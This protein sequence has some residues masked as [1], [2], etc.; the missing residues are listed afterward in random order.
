MTRAR[1]QTLYRQ[2]FT[3]AVS[4]V[5]TGGPFAS[6][7]FFAALAINRRYY[8]IR[9]SLSQFRQHSR[10]SCASKPPE[11]RHDVNSNIWMVPLEIADYLACKRLQVRRIGVNSDTESSWLSRC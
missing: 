8:E 10:S 2:D 1:P 3:A 7:D 9:C 4:G 5:G 11:V 6:P